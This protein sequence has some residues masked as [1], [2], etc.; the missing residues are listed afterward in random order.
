VSTSVSALVPT[1]PSTTAAL[2]FSPRSFARFIGGPLN[3]PLNSSGVICRIS[4]ASVRA[5]LLPNASRAT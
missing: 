5:S 1:L 4:R 2:R 3:A